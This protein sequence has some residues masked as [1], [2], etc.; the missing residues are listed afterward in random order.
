M[1]VRV[2]VCPYQASCWSSKAERPTSN[3]TRYSGWGGCW[4]GLWALCFSRVSSSRRCGVK[5]SQM[6]HDLRS[7]MSGTCGY[8]PML[9]LVRRE[10]ICLVSTFL[11]TGVTAAVDFPHCVFR[12]YSTC[13][14]KG[15]VPLNPPPSLST[16]LVF[17]SEVAAAR[18][19]AIHSI[20]VVL[21]SWCRHLI[22]HMTVN[23]V[24]ANARTRLRLLFG[25]P[26]LR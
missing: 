15:G 4:G 16:P 7:L 26:T 2:C 22:E 19:P 3:R 11:R 6:K 1:C 24:N 21:A 10:C 23:I 5:S 14:R 18:F 17:G 12:V 8:D 25:P 9:Y 20:F 13:P